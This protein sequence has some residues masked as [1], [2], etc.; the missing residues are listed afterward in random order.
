MTDPFIDDKMAEDFR[1]L[2]ELEQK[3]APA[4]ELLLRPHNGAQTS[5][6]FRPPV[7]LALAASAVLI[8][9]V[10]MMNPIPREDSTGSVIESR[11]YLDDIQLTL[12]DEMPTD[13]LL[14][15]PW[16]QLASTTPQFQLLIPSYEYLE[17]R[18]DEP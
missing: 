18:S 8:M 15:T 5:R 10:I 12:A 2:R 6:Y 14:D 11:H 17:E 16:F 4:F 9:L 1:R 7:R 13:F 3:S